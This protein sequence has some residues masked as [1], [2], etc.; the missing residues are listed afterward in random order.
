MTRDHDD[1]YGF[2]RC[3][4]RFEHE[5]RPAGSDRI[6][7][8]TH[9]SC[10]HR[11]RAVRIGAVEL[12]IVDLQVSALLVAQ[13]MQLRYECAIARAWPSRLKHGEAKDFSRLTRR[14]GCVGGDIT[15]PASNA[16]TLRR[17]IL[18]PRRR[19]SGRGFFRLVVVSGPP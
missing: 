14:R 19:P 5:L 2:C 10:R 3:Y 11:K 4:R 7:T 18:A 12:D 16:R 9:E 1:R 13:R 6:D 8:A 15:A 17:L